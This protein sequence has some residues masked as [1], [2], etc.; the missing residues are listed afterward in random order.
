MILKFNA[1][2]SMYET[3]DVLPERWCFT[4][5]RN[6][7]DKDGKSLGNCYVCLEGDIN[8]TREQMFEARGAK[9]S[10][11]YNQADH[12]SCDPD[13]RWETHEVELKDVWLDRS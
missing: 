11:Q 4:F 9:W 10:M 13:G 5:G 8:S 6:H 12:T 3:V 2:G 7:V 1:D